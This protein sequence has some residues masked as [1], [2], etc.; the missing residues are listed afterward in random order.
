[1]HGEV[2]QVSGHETP[3]FS[4][5]DL[6]LNTPKNVDPMDVPGAG[7]ALAS[8]ADDTTWEGNKLDDPSVEDQFYAEPNRD[9]WAEYEPTE[10]DIARLRHEAELHESG[11]GPR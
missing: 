11:D 5:D 2:A 4:W 9:G 8:E 1:M 10:Q 7:D 6:D 3:A